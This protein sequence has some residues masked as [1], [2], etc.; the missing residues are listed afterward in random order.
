[1]RTSEQTD[2]IDVALAKAQAEMTNPSQDAKN[3]HFRN[4]YASLASVRNAVI[5]VLAKHGIA[6]MQELISVDNKV[7]CATRLSHAGQ[8]IEFDALLL[9]AG[10]NDAQGY[11]SAC[12]YARRYSL[13][14]VAGVFGDADDD[15]NVASQSEKKAKPV[16]A[17]ATENPVTPTAGAD[18]RVSEDRKPILGEYVDGFNAAFANGDQLQAAEL[19]EELTDADEKTY[20]WS[21]LDS[22]TRSFIKAAIAAAN[23]AQKEAA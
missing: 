15:G 20:V 1:M 11:G 9:P 23:P 8:W 13:Q 10:K 2:K 17:K 18:E 12:T 16:L 21:F 5:P 22:K 7:G 14:A 3:D 4:R 19:A 6:C